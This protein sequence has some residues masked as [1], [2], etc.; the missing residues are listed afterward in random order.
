MKHRFGCRAAAVLLTWAAVQTMFCAPVFA[1]PE[2]GTD[3]TVQTA[4]ETT[5]PAETTSAST[6]PETT[7]TEE[8]VT[9][10]QTTETE[11]T[12]AATVNVLTR[13]Q[14]EEAGSGGMRITRYQWLNERLVE[15]PDTIEGRPVTEIGAEAF[16][17]CYADE[18][19]LPSSLLLIGDS[20][21]AGCAYLT[22]VQIPQGC[23]YIGSSAFENCA[24]LRSVHVPD[25]VTEIGRQAF[26]ETPF[27]AEQ[28]EDFVILGSGVLYSYQGSAERVTLPDT[29]QTI[30]PMAFAG[31]ET[32]RSV[33]LPASLRRIR[34]TAFDGCTALSEIQAETAPAAVEAGAFRSTRWYAEPASDFLCIG[35]LLY[36]YRG[37]AAEVRVPDGIKVIGESAFLGNAR[38]SA[39]TLPDS[40]EEIRYAAFSGCEALQVAE[41]GD[42]MQSIGDAAF[43]G[44]SALRYLRTGHSLTEIGSQAFTG[45]TALSELHLPD[46]LN[47]IGTQA[48][49]Y[50]A[51]AEDG[52][53]R[54][55]DMAVTLFSNAEAAKDYAKKNGLLSA[56]LPEEEN[57]AP[58]PE[59]TTTPA[60]RSGLRGPNGT[61]WVPAVLAGGA[62]VLTGLIGLF[63]RRLIRRR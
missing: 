20:A 47:R 4:A 59:I 43:S 25:S 48:I 55:M 58:A 50:V 12:T 61:L 35:G 5:L 63:L 18:I 32:I 28:T 38:L 41:L 34:A 15:L 9:A 37:E 51:D 23:R 49:G 54:K 62:L 27:L 13:L 6:L 40:A 26:A 30:A 31:N 17:Y 14:Y 7:V 44:D 19:R 11:Q 33:T 16:R 60:Q 39:V 53:V 56:P 10:E 2:D 24:L 46:S 36:A 22:D 21:F 52:S 42:G 1:E 8:T 57:T 29:V 45:C 3:T